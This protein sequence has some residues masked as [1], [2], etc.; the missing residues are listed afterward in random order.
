MALCGLIA[1][2]ASLLPHRNPT[3]AMTEA[4]VMLAASSRQSTP[5]P[6]PAVPRLIPVQQ[7]HGA[8]IMQRRV[9]NSS[10]R[11][12]TARF[13]TPEIEKMLAQGCVQMQLGCNSCS[14][15]YEN[16]G[17]EA[18]LCADGS[19]LDMHCD[20]KQICTHKLCTV[21]S[22]EMPGCDSRI[23]RMGCRLTLFET[24][25]GNVPVAGKRTPN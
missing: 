8:T 9:P 18:R 20:R 24:G 4:P 6:R 14:V 5:R 2:C 23:S 22:E 16:C 25:A 11:V 17:P 10:W 21:E 7:C 19:C 12:F 1:A 3:L 13:E 15:R